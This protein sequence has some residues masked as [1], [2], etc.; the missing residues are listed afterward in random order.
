MSKQVIASFFLIIFSCSCMNKNTREAASDKKDNSVI[1]GRNNDNQS[2]QKSIFSNNPSPA[3]ILQ[4]IKVLETLS[5][6]SNPSKR[7][8]PSADDIKGVELLLNEYKEN[9]AFYD[10]YVEPVPVEEIQKYLDASHKQKNLMITMN[11]YPAVL[12]MVAALMATYLAYEM[13]KAIT[14]EITP[15]PKFVP[16]KET[17]FD[18]PKLEER[19]LHHKKNP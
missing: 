7:K 11:S 6:M 12:G 4:Q 8:N 13:A 9:K 5:R 18:L 19:Q 3:E 14:G 15:A 1:L 16:I 10:R 17:S 2:M